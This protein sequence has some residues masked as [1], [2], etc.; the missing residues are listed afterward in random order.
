MGSRFDAYSHHAE[1]GIFGILLGSYGLGAVTGA[2]SV[3]RLKQKLSSEAILRLA[4]IALSVAT[5]TIAFSRNDILTCLA[6]ATAGGGWMLVITTLNIAVQLP[7]PRWVTGRA[8]ATFQASVAGGI[9]IGSWGWG[10]VADIL[11]V[12]TALLISAGGIVASVLFGLRWKMHEARSDGARE[13]PDLPDPD[14]KLAVT[15]R[16]GPVVVELEYRVALDDARSFYRIMQEVQLSRQRNGA[17]AWSIARD[18]AD[19]ELWVER[20]HFPTWIDFLR[21]R[22]RP[23]AGERQLEDRAGAFQIGGEP[24]RIRRMLERPFGS[25]RWQAEA[26]DRGLQGTFMPGP[27]GGA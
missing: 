16:S 14:V 1:A 22:N 9:A 10:A 19:P 23:T 8:L 25:V 27:G 2:F 4:T 18:L 13:S 12:Q 15:H 17:Y 21:M 7:V 6:L 11:D 24:V 20:F 3:S 26:R 5:C